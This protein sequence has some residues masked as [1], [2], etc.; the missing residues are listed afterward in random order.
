MHHLIDAGY[1]SYVRSVY[2]LHMYVYT[3]APAL[4]LK[5]HH[6]NVINSQTGED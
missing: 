4:I 1:G 3:P 5:R 6:F 2:A